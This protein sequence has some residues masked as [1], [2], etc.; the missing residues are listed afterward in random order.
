MDSMLT[1]NDS[2][3]TFLMESGSASL[4]HL[5]NGSGQVSTPEMAEVSSAKQYKSRYM[6]LE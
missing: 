1:W 3:K 4:E 5:L 2:N 6:P